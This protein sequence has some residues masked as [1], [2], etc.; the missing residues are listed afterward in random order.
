VIVVHIFVMTHTGNLVVKIT[1]CGTR[2]DP[3][4]KENFT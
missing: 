3:I 1:R 2:L 4:L